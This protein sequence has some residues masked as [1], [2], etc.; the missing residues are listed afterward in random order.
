MP[1]ILDQKRRAHRFVIDEALVEPAMLAEVKALVG[2]VD[3]DRAAI[4]AAFLQIVEHRADA[5]VDRRDRPQI[6][7]HVPLIFPQRDLALRALSG[8]P[9]AV[10]ALHH[11]TTTN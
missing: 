11:R 10:L 3:D 5:F 7:L 8:I 4:E 6:L 9:S 2:G 1:R